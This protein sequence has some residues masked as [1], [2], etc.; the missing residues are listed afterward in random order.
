MCGQLVCG[1]LVVLCLLIGQCNG[2][3][4]SSLGS[5]DRL[6]AAVFEESLPVPVKLL[7]N[8]LPLR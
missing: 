6:G 8:W 4:F 3:G 5:A 2:K 7:E 1:S